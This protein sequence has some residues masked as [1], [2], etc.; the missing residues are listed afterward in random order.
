MDIVAMWMNIACFKCKTWMQKSS[1][2]LCPKK[3]FLH[4]NVT[5]ADHIPCTAPSQSMILFARLSL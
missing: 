5:N 1:C 4:R 2:S 3:Q